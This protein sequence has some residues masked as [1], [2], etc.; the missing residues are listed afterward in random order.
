MKNSKISLMM[1]INR[2]CREGQIKVEKIFLIGKKKNQEDQ[3]KEVSPNKI[4]EF[5]MKWKAEKEIL[6]KKY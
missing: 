3:V 1:K 4:R 6:K 2:G 5:E